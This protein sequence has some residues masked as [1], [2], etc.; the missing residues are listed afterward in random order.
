MFKIKKGFTLAEMMVV[1]LILSIVLAAM[2]PVMTT[3]NKTDQTSPWRY[4][5][6]NLSD[7]YYG[8]GESQTAMIGQRQ[9]ENTDET[10]K[11][12]INSSNT[13]P[14]SIAF[15]KNGENIAKLF[16]R[17]DADDKSFVLGDASTE[18][19]NNTVIGSGT[20]SEGSGDFNTMLG[21]DTMSRTTK[22]SY[23]VAIGT[24]ALSG[25]YGTD[26]NIAIGY[27]TLKN[28]KGLNRGLN[29][30]PGNG[31]IAI[32]HESQ[33]SI[34]DMT[35]HRGNTSIGYQSLKTCTSCGGNTGTGWGTLRLITQGDGNSAFGSNA[36]ASISTGN[37]NTAL[38]ECAMTFYSS[39]TGNTAVGNS[40]MAP[41]AT[42][43]YNTALG[44]QAMA[45]F[46]T[47]GNGNT[48]L[49]AYTNVQ[50]E[51]SIAI[52]GGI[53]EEGASVAEGNQALAIGYK[54]SS[55]ADN[56]IAIGN[57]AKTSDN[58]A[59]AIGNE[60]TA[61]G[62]SSIA[63]GSHAEQ[64]TT[65]ALGEKSIA[66]GDG[67]VA[68]GNASVAIGNNAEAKGN[69]NI[70]IGN[71]ACKNMKGSN[72][73]CIGSFSGS[74][75]SEHQDDDVERIYIGGASKL[76]KGSAVL[77]VHN[78]SSKRGNFSNTAVVIHGN[79]VVNGLIFSSNSRNGSHFEYQ[80]RGDDNGH[81]GHVIHFVD[82]NDTIKNYYRNGTVE[83]R[84]TSDSRLKYVGS[85]NTSGLDKIRQLKVFNYTFKK[86]EKKTPHVGVIA[87]D[88]QKIFPDAVKK[89]ADGFLTI[90]MEDM[91]YAVINAIKELDAKVAA[92]DKK[93]KELEARIEKLEAKL[94]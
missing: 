72:K 9:F 12:I 66:I 10:A 53:N 34:G 76:N 47:S 24:S 94:K 59:I 16:I 13:R 14:V 31:S 49:G 18:S 8:L 40:A 11:L 38:G 25:G 79:L 93:I 35:G 69:N 56:S 21:S 91:F 50:G 89:G 70:A 46:T 71:Y 87:Q 27:N 3:R 78:D 45:E 19:K 58:D 15:K 5:E 4:S 2:A 1:M 30:W 43:N 65:S 54:A 63:I 28:I 60:V 29:Y 82:N 48:A 7:A 22:S 83:E 88:L 20:F 41:S 62:E 37:S 23:N 52:G 90:R 44:F 67:A 85:E 55:K 73:I 80:S 51:N 61:S 57:T 68:T 26:G 81:T 84:K 39:G 77:E 17:K 32:G 74:N 64:S 42:G 75:S 86:D 92:Q 6:G 33:A 36:L